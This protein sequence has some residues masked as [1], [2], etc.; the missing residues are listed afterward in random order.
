[1]SLAYL[2]DMLQLALIGVGRWGTN[3]LNILNT[4][5]GCRV[6]YVCDVT[7]TLSPLVR[8]RST[9]GEPTIL[10]NHR[11]LL[12]KTD[13][14]AVIIATPGSTHAAIALPFIKKGLPVYIE[15]PL[16]TSLK[17]ATRLVAAA[18]KSGSLIFPGHIHL[19]NPAYL[20]A[21]KMASQAG[22]IRFLYAEGTNN[23]PFRDDMSALW[24]WAPHDVYLTLDL[25]NRP[26]ASV[27][28]WGI[29]TLRPNTTLYD[30]TTLKVTFPGNI[31][32]VSV[33]SWLLPNKQKRLTIVGTRDTVVFDDAALR[34][35]AVYKNMGPSF[36]KAS[37]YAKATADKPA[38]KP[39][40]IIKHEPTV[41]HP[42]YSN[43]PSLRAELEAFLK[44]IRTKAR[45]EPYVA[46]GLNVVRILAAAERSMNL[47]GKK[48]Q[49]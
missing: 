33:T 18:K 14:D 45:P 44:A 2:A 24:D 48:I 6:A 1:M 3:I 27:Q 30:F 37:A 23:G 22:K 29:K 43:K 28:A 38:G 47:D 5:R 9:G 12:K 34:K 25:I 8:G 17:D 31:S 42:A 35:V 40:H 39:A 7:P 15:K 49:L 41:L 10:T 21:K 16:T 19:F 4:I 36:A 26:P 46:Q 32:L 11:D 13:L 20:T